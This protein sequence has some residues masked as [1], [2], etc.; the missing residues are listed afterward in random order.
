MISPRI[1]VALLTAG[2]LASISAA[3]ALFLF[4]SSHP[5]KRDAALVL[6]F[7][8]ALLAAGLAVALLLVDRRAAP[9]LA[10]LHAA[11]VALAEQERPLLVSASG[12]SGLAPL[13]DAWNTL[14]RA[15]TDGL[16]TLQR[17][18]T[19]LESLLSAGADALVVLDRQK[20]IR[21]LNPAAGTLF[22]GSVGRSFAEAVRNHELTGHLD[23]A[24]AG[25]PPTSPVYLP[26]RDLWLQLRA[27][28]ADYGGE[29]ATVVAL[30]DISEV[31]RAETARRDF[32]A[33]V[34][35]ELR[36]PLAGIKAVV[37][38]LRDG[39][40]NEPATAT[41]F[42]GLVDAEVDR[43]VQLV[44][45]L[46][47]LARLESGAVMVM[48]DVAPRDVLAAV[49]ERFQVQSERAGVRLTV[50]APESLPA[51]HADPA[52][53]GQAVGNLVHNALKFTS[54]GGTVTITA[55]SELADS[56][57]IT[58]TDTGSGIDPADLPRIFERFYTADRVRGGHG[59]G[60]GLAIVKHVVRAHGG[61]VEARSRLG[62]GSEFTIRLPLG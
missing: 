51:I 57:R 7:G 43:L 1:R 12:H 53:L 16:A 29:P 60:L 46:L 10:E 39:A 34:S 48:S 31:R 47:Q 38:T 27:Q 18:R 13:M 14:A 11:M 35:H 50:D 24:L 20:V 45:E 41:E 42:L 28:P 25:R 54:E 61:T 37:E 6:L 59:V 56:L 52:R 58:V 36:T 22:G 49:V 8:L 9:P 30:H 21:F 15:R 5:S 19:E 40:L 2:A 62:L 17:E 26:A 55:A 3:L 4:L 44:E 33:N 32:V 23:D